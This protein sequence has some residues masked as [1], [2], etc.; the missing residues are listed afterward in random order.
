MPSPEQSSFDLFADPAPVAEPKPKPAKP[1]KAAKP[2]NEEFRLIHTA[3]W[4]LGKMLGDLSRE[5]EHDRFLDFLLE[6]IER[7]SIDALIIAGDV[8]DSAN[9]PQ[10]ALRRY[11]SFLSSLHA[12]TNCS[13][14]V[15]AGN[16]DSPALIEAPG[17]LLSALRVHVVGVLPEKV[18]EAIIALPSEDNPKLLVAAVPF[19]RDRDVRTGQSGQ[20]AEEIRKDLADGIRSRYTE[21]AEAAAARKLP[22]VA[23]GHLT[24]SG[25]S[26]SDSEREIHIGGLGAVNSSIFP[27]SLAYIALGHLHRPQSS[28]SGDRVRYSGSPIPLSFSE[29]K[30]HK[31]VRLLTFNASGEL[32]KNESFAIPNARHLVQL[33]CSRDSLD[34]TLRNFAPPRGALETWVEIVVEGVA[35]GENLVEQVRESATEE[36]YQIIRVMG[37]RASLQPALNE[38]ETENEDGANLL[39]NHEEVFRIRLEQ[40]ES[41]TPDERT[42]V[43]ATFRELLSI[44]DDRQREEVA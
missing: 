11:Y 14:V 35:P 22:T 29:A 26:V 25:S 8:F 23:M 30:D 34:E 13:V 39:E 40:E 27:E 19:L 38:S 44:Y 3:D 4:H 5:E 12:R 6:T 2:K 42:A 1:K 43:E 15:T 18:E 32:A 16:H 9:P 41:L 28:G 24:V 21:I 20:S 17:D 7:E 36:G 10:S 31:E 37:N 33:N